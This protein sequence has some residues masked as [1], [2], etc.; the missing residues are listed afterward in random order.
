MSLSR[1]RKKELRRLQDQAGKL[2][3]SQQVLVGEAA[4]V[5]RE[6]GRQLGHY[7]REHIAPTVQANYDKYAAPYVEKGVK[8]A[9]QVFNEKLVPAAGTVVGSAMS[10]WDAANDTRSKLAAGRGLSLPD[11]DALGKKAQ[12]NSKKAS[13]K[14]SAKVNAAAQAATPKKGMSAG[15]VIALIL[16]VAAAVGVIYAAWQTLRADDELWVADDP[17]RAPDA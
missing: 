14:I 11:F 16:G 4:S 17:L 10:V 5:A 2:W 1:K 12:K 3:E 8:T 6:A 15:G 7:N 13:K 9:Q